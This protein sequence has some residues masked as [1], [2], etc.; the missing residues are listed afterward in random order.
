MTILVDMDEVLDQLLQ[1]W[2]PYLNKKY[3][4]DVDP[5]D[6]TG[7]WVTDFYPGL[8]R[9]QVYGA[10]KDEEL[11]ATVKPVPGASE[12]L[13]KLMADGHEIFVV[14][15]SD[16]RTVKIKM[17]TVLFRYFPFLSWDNVILTAKKQMIRGDVL[18]DDGI[19]NLEGGDYHKLLMDAPH[20]RA[21]DAGIH[22]MYRVFNWEDIYRVIQH[23][24]QRN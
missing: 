9:K 16:Y 22:G 3:G 1:A 15:N 17:E 7:W 10:L 19:H 12:G 18:I 8:T 5:E 6:V 11:W 2:I 20:N 13:R 14:T 21:Y 24:D 4:M 23:I